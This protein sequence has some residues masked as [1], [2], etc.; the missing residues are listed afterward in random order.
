MVK[1]RSP[2]HGDGDVGPVQGA[3]LRADAL[4]VEDHR[5]VVLPHR[6]LAVG[7]RRHQRLQLLPGGEQ[8]LDG[9]PPV[10]LGPARAAQG[11]PTET[12]QVSRRLG[13][14]HPLT[15]I[16]PHCPINAPLLNPD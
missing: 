5:E 6:H 15:A 13:I 16:P 14:K 1:M 12:Q 7:Q 2:T 9:P 11:N 4:L 3:L 8:L 10:H